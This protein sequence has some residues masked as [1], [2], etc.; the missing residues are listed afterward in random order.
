MFPMEKAVWTLLKDHIYYNDEKVIPLIRRLT[1][2]DETPCITIEQ[3]AEVQMKRIQTHDLTE[4]VLLKNNSEVWVNIWCNTEEERNSIVG[5]VETRILQALSNHHTTCNNYNDG[6]CKYL[7]D[8]CQVLTITNGRTAKKQCPYPKKNHYKNWFNTYRII[9]HSFN[10]SGKSNM[11][12]LDITP[13]ILRTLLQLNMDYY[14]PYNI[15]GSV[16]SDFTIKEEK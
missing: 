11:D 16:L 14:A 5:Q 2:E 8:T 7:E 12:E 9:K 13:P 3:A 4:Q 1:S 6:D 15:G 10:I